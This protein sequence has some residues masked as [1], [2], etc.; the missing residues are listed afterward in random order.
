M[1][2]ATRKQ[3]RQAKA[4]RRWIL[5]VYQVD[6]QGLRRDHRTIEVSKYFTNA[7]KIINIPASTALAPYVPNFAFCFRELI[8]YVYL[9]LN[10]CGPGDVRLR[11]WPPSPILRR[12]QDA[13][14]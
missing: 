5:A 8:L 3:R 6:L 7:L 13:P 9:F 10:E 11:S 4:S 1:K 2:L 14:D 12:V